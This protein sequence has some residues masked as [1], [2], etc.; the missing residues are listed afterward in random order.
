MSASRDGTRLGVS[1]LRLRAALGAAIVVS[2]VGALGIAGCRAAPPPVRIAYEADAAISLDPVVVSDASARSLLS[3]FFEPL[4]G[5]DPQMGFVPALAQSW[6]N[7]GDRTWEI[8]LRP[9]VLF[10]DGTPLTAKVAVDAL[11]RARTDPRSTERHLLAAVSDIDVVDEHKLRLRLM[12][13]VPDPVLANRLPTILIGHEYKGEDGVTRYAGTGPYRPVSTTGTAVDAQAYDRY[14]GPRPVMATARFLQVP[15]SKRSTLP[16]EA[17]VYR[18]VDP[19]P[20]GFHGVTGEGQSSVYLWVN[21]EGRDRDRQPL[22]DPR[23]RQA[24]AR[25]VDR[26]ALLPHVPGGADVLDQPVPRQIFG[27]IPDLRSEGPSAAR[28]R[29]LLAAAGY[30]S[31]FETTLSYYPLGSVSDDVAATLAGQLAAIGI[32]ARLE[33]L[34]GADLLERWRGQRVALLLAP[35]SFDNGDAYS[36]L[37]D[38]VHSRDGDAAGAFNAGFQSPDLDSLIDDLGRVLDVRARHYGPVM[39]AVLEQA[40]FIPLFQPRLNYAVRDGFVWSPRADGSIRAAEVS[41]R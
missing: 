8:E 1:L 10:H 21:A 17:D 25:A 30:R 19:L 40:P 12:T 2:A 36:F 11:Q 31:G 34:E 22:A 28:A 39:R 35:W 41:R 32:R 29:E 16:L 18:T 38:C 27:H 6:N 7:V 24:L 14:W 13:A 3:N 33:P 5:F 4:V 37:V 20:P 15:A 23:V 26:P 9:G